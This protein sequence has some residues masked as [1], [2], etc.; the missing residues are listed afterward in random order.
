MQWQV[1]HAA[2]SEAPSRRTTTQP[3][4]ALQLQLTAADGTRTTLAITTGSSASNAMAHL[5]NGAPT[6]L[7]II[8]PASESISDTVAACP[9]RHNTRSVAAAAP[10]AAASMVQI[11][12]Q[13]AMSDTRQGSGDTAALQEV[14]LMTHSEASG[15]AQPHG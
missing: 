2:Q 13:F 6:T 15:P 8:G 1:E 14:S 4:R 3:N 7:C 10:R 9:S 11:L 5:R 12:R